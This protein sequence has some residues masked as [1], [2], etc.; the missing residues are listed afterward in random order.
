MSFKKPLG[1]PKK[2]QVFYGE[3]D[4][5]AVKGFQAWDY[6]LVKHALMPGKTS[7]PGT[8]F[9]SRTFGMGNV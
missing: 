9:L 6:V 2:A 1:P 4:C 5:G 7:A 3:M 8:R